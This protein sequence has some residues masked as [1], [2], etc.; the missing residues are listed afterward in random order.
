LSV[1]NRASNNAA[2][3]WPK[4]AMPPNKPMQPTAFGAR[5]HWHFEAIPCGAP[6]RRLMRNP[7]GTRGNVIAIPF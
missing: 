1:N 3:H 6:R 2:F 5:D 4:P 7:F